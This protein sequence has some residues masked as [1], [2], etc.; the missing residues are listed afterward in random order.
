[1]VDQ[2]RLNRSV[3]QESLVKQSVNVIPVHRLSQAILLLIGDVLHS[4]RRRHLRLH[5][6]STT[7]PVSVPRALVLLPLS[8]RQQA[9]LAL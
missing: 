7:P 4:R 5:R 6:S 3:L 9:Q 8:V 2:H 1:M